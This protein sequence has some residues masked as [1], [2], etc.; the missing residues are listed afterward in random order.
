MSRMT[1]EARRAQ[2]LHTAASV[3][4]SRGYARATTKE[5]AR[6]AGVTEPIIYRHFASKRDLFIALIRHAGEETLSMWRRHLRGA[7]DPAER[8]SRLLGDN[9][10]VTPEGRDAY[11]VLLQAITVSDDEQIHAAIQEHFHAL[12]AFLTGELEKAQKSHRVTT[13]FDAS[14]IA[15]LLIDIG[16]GYGVLSALGV[17]GHGQSESGGHVRD[18][19][20]RLL[21]GPGRKTRAGHPPGDG[22]ARA[23]G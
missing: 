18:V 9:P 5:I 23:K 8:L 12:H 3:F 13:R 2:L 22:A 15:W 7:S 16:L 1:A 6:A 10:M 4:S 21:I 20:A 11:R 17:E 19:I 14:L